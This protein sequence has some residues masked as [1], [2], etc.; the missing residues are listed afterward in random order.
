MTMLV[1][2]E[3]WRV[4][5]IVVVKSAFVFVYGGECC[6]VYLWCVLCQGCA[7]C[8][9]C[10]LLTVVAVA[11]AGVVNNGVMCRRGLCDA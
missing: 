10:R 5:V 11:A 2:G 4:R 6:V 3:W 9:G 1:C 7:A 8:V